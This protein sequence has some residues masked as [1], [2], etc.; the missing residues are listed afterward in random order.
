MP[1]CLIGQ[2]QR[3]PRTEFK[4]TVSSNEQHDH[5]AKTLT[6]YALPESLKDMLG[7][8]ASTSSQLA[9]TGQWHRVRLFVCHTADAEELGILWPSVL[10]SEL[11][12]HVDLQ[13]QVACAPTE[14][15][16]AS[17]RWIL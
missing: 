17:R 2:S 9:A 10:G 3:T 12:R 15:Y 11:D 4:S 5:W 14:G 7:P 16:M 1:E 8:R 6:N 13:W